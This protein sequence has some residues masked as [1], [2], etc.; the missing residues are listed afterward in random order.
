MATTSAIFLA[1]QSRAASRLKATIY[2][3]RGSGQ[4]TVPGRP[5]R[6]SPAPRHGM[7]VVPSAIDRGSHGVAA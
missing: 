4:E 3:A 5:V 7:P 6:C 1:A 2:P